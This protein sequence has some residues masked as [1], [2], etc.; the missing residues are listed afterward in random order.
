MYNREIKEQFLAE[1]DGNR[2]IGARP[3]LELISVYE[4]RLQKDLAEM[5]LDEVTEAISGL[6]IG[7][8]KTA[9]GVQSFIR[10][11]VKWC[12]QFCKFKNVNVELCSISADDIYDDEI[13]AI[14]EM[15]VLHG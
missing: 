15:E 1:Y 6:N 4:E 9:A 8:Y 3:N 5:S 7:T 12:D 13:V 11:Y 10:S 14:A 2:V